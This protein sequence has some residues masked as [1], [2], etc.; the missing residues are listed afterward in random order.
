MLYMSKAR[1][2]ALALNH[3]HMTQ[4]HGQGS[5]LPCLA[6]LTYGANIGLCATSQTCSIER[7]KTCLPGADQTQQHLKVWH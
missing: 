4:F 7:L 3:N 2:A 1:R 6:R 5:K